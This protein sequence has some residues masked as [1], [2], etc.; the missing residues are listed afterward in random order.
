MS[1][2]GCSA[3]STVREEDLTAPSKSVSLSRFSVSTRGFPNGR[4]EQGGYT[5]SQPRALHQR[6]LFPYAFVTY[7]LPHLGA[8]SAGHAPRS[9][10]PRPC[11]RWVGNPWASIISGLITQPMG[12]PG[13]PPRICLPK[14]TPSTPKVIPTTPPSAGL[15]ARANVTTRSSPTLFTPRSLAPCASNSKSS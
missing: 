3:C 13:L 6:G 8:S 2:V 14:T 11:P 10:A 1:T 9:F 7:G 15:L 5:P 12:K 4:C